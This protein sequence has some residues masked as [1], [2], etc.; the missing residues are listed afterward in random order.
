MII[1]QTK[2][3]KRKRGGEWVSN[4]W[5]DYTWRWKSQGERHIEKQSWE[6]NRPKRNW[7]YKWAG[8]QSALHGGLHL[9]LP[10]WQIRVGCC[11][12]IMGLSFHNLM[13]DVAAFYYIMPLFLD[14]HQPTYFQLFLFLFF[15]LKGFG[16]FIEV[17]V[18]WW[19]L[20]FLVWKFHIFILAI[21]HRE[22]IPP[23][24]LGCF[25]WGFDNVFKYHQTN[26]FY[27]SNK[28]FIKAYIFII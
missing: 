6:M 14:L 15:S 1:R 5:L 2:K 18:L 28:I 21:T 13:H 22:F 9:P 11:Y 20:R 12:R 16:V 4:N 27:V 3:E 8:G 23:M 19:N 26:A 25:F 7:F 17:P 10:L 24:P